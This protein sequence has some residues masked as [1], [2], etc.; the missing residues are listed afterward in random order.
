MEE[1]DQERKIERLED[2]EKERHRSN[3]I[4]RDRRVMG[5]KAKSICPNNA[6]RGFERERLQ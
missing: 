1:S 4:W 3:C 5:N 2:K 6:S